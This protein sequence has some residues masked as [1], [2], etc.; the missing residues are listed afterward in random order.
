MDPI[1]SREVLEACHYYGLDPHD[2][3]SV[4]TVPTEMVGTMPTIPELL[5]AYQQRSK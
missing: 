1:I 5:E 2:L 4:Y 3:R